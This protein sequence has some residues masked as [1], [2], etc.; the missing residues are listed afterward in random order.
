[1]WFGYFIFK[2]WN[3]CYFS[4]QFCLDLVIN[5]IRYDIVI[6]HTIVLGIFISAQ[7]VLVFSSLHK[8]TGQFFSLNNILDILISVQRYFVPVSHQK[9]TWYFNLC[10]NICC[11]CISSYRY[12]I[13]LSLYKDSL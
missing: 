1:M 8:R 9:G 11:T 10:A 7:R 2:Q 13:F 3:F 5:A 12:L 4:T 6:I